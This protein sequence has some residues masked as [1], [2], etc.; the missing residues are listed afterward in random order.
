MKKQS[1]FGAL[2]LVFLLA[3]FPSAVSSQ[4]VTGT[5]LGTV[6]D[7]KG[8]AVAN[9]TIRITNSDQNVVVRT[10]TTDER[11]QFT[12][13]LLPVGRYGVTA[14]ICSFANFPSTAATTRNSFFWCLG[15]QI[16]GTPT[17]FS[18]GQPLRSVPT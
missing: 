14:E 10:V 15:H 12:V 9:V 3:V 16:P 17:R 13:P 6:S 7:S 18:L 11:G 2:V 1:I 4:S 5:I 8:G